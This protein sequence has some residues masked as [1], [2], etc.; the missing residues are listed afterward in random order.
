MTLDPSQFDVEKLS[1]RVAERF[2][3]RKQQ[4]ADLVAI[5]SIAWDAHDPSEL[6]RSAAVIERMFADLNFFDWTKVASASA[7]PTGAPAVLARRAAKNGR[8]HVLLYA[9]HDV[10]PVGD[11]SLWLSKPFEAQERAGRLYGRGAADDKAG[12]LVHLESLLNLIEFSAEPDL[13]ISLFIEGEEEAGSPS[14]A[15]F[16]D[17][18]RA[19]LEADVIVVADSGNWTTDIPA[20]TTSLRGL[21]SQTIKISTLDHALHSGMY[22]GAVPDSLTAMIRLLASLHNDAGDVAIEGLVSG[23]AAQLA[24]SD[25]QLALDSGLLPGVE[26]LGSGSILSRLWNKPAATVLAID[27]PSVALASN[28]LQP[29]TRAKVSLRIAPGENPQ[30]ALGLLR[31]HLVKNTPFGAQLEFED[32]EAGDPYLDHPDWAK[33]LAASALELS[34]GCK[35]VDMGVGGSIPFIA[36]FKEIFPEAQI[37]VT[38]VEDP[39]SRAHSPNESLH[40][41]SFKKAMVAQSL[42]L[43][44]TNTKNIGN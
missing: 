7:V 15:A 27:A 23:E 9:H 41:E 22:G 43:L 40:L 2:E 12:I 35:P 44:A 38:G 26:Q 24:Y 19:D 29:S 32:F 39:D 16:L 34:F 8:P 14:F 5:P 33:P 21:V 13:G 31:E 30:R 11:E 20:L 6:W 36:K 1:L 10:Q 37:L 4:L 25:E 42:F 28:T 18:H 3:T 17:E